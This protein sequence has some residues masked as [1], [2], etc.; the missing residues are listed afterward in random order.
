MD[1]LWKTCNDLDSAA[2][3]LDDMLQVMTLIMEAAE[4]ADRCIKPDESHA[5]ERISDAYGKY[6]GLM[7][8]VLGNITDLCKQIQRLTN[9]AFELQRKERAVE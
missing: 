4:H 1:T 9:E 6:F 2:T 3:S 5:A 7:Y 8:A